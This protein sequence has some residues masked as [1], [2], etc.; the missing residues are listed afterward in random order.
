MNRQ[1]PGLS[2]SVGSGCFRE[3]PDGGRRCQNWQ[4][5][6]CCAL[7]GGLD[8]VICRINGLV[9]FLGMFLGG[10]ACWGVSNWRTRFLARGH[11]D[12]LPMRSLPMPM[13]VLRR[14]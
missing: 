9:S 5:W 10:A 12:L 2:G 3:K 4:L 6:L 1:N 11:G 7:K 8:A 14:P 13:E